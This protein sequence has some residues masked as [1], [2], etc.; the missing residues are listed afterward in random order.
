MVVGASPHVFRRGRPA[1]ACHRD[2]RGRDH[3]QNLDEQLRQRVEELQT[4][5]D[6]APVALVTATDAD[7]SEVVGNGAAYRM[8]E[9]PAGSNL[10]FAGSGVARSWRVRGE[11]RAGA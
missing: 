11:R 9:T 6:V 2:Y 4:V 8:L 7:C 5:M 3:T 10:S 1:G